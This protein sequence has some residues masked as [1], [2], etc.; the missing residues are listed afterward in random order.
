MTSPWRNDRAVPKSSSAAPAGY[1]SVSRIAELL[2]VSHD[3]VRRIASDGHLGEPVR[4]HRGGQ[5]ARYYSLT[6]VEAVRDGLD[7]GSIDRRHVSNRRGNTSKAKCGTDAG[8]QAHCRRGEPACSECV[9][10]HKEY[11]Q[12]LAERG[13]R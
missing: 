5:V 6:S 4:V 9:T 8:F 7:D 2:E 13:A 1:A 11:R 3:L 12:Q 10:A